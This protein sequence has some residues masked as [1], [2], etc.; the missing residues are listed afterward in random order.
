MGS[1][2]AVAAGYHVAMMNERE[3]RYPRHYSTA[4]RAL[5]RYALVFLVVGLLAGVAYQESAKKVALS[6]GA[7]GPSYWDATLRL[8]LVHG[9]L[10]VTGV[11]LPVAMAGMLHLALA[12]GGRAVSSRALAWTLGTYLPCVAVTNALMIYKG[13]HILLSVRAG[14]TDMGRIDANLFGG[15]AALRHAMYGLSH[16]GMAFGLCLFAWCLWRSLKVKAAS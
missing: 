15:I 1:D 14:E 6:S 13:Y 10:I 7:D 3:S 9:H 4:I 16:T 11:L 2:T 12:H 5:L 8:A